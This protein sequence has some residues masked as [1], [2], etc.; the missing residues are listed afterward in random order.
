MVNM[1]HGILPACTEEVR[2]DVGLANT[3]LGIMGSIVYLGLVVGKSHPS[4]NQ[5]MNRLHVR[6]SCLQLLQHQVRSHSVSTPKRGLS[7]PF[8]L[9][10]QL[11][12]LPAL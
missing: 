11:L 10:Q 1:D 7:L 3:D 5:I 4:L 6:Y 8:H 2:Q 12:C 9:L